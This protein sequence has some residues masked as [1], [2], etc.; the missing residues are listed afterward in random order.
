MTINQQNEK[1]NQTYFCPLCKSILS[2][3]NWIRITGLW[4]EQQKAAEETKKQISELKKQ[5]DEQEK[6][7]NQE[8]KK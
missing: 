3:E 6:Q 4:A 5:N 2:K 8:M 7:H 1:T